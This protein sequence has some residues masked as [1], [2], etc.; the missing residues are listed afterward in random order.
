MNLESNYS[1]WLFFMALVLQVE[2]G[3]LY[4]QIWLGGLGLSSWK[5]CAGLHYLLLNVF[6]N[7]NLISVI[8]EKLSY[9]LRDFCKPR[10]IKNRFLS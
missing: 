10:S 2:T 7:I 6:E 3:F 8:L 1:F 9:P 5:G 4:C